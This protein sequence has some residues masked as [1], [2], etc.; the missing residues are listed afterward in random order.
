METVQLVDDRKTNGNPPAVYYR[1]R[2]DYRALIPLVRHGLNSNDPQVRAFLAQN[3]NVKMSVDAG[4]QMHASDIL[5]RHLAPANLK[6][7]VVVL[8]PDSGDLLA[9]VSYPWPEEDQFALFRKNADRTIAADWQDRALFGLYPPGSSFKLVT[10][11]AALR[12]NPNADREVFE[13]KALGDGRVG[14]YVGK[15]NRPIRDDIQDKIPHGRVDMT[16][17]IIVS[18]NAFFAQLGYAMGAAPLLETAQ[19]FHIS[20]SPGDSLARLRQRLPQAAYGQGEVVAT[21]FQMARVAATIADNGAMPQGRWVIDESNTRADEPVAVLDVQ[22]T[23]KIAS[24]MRQVV[25][26]PAGTGKVLRNAPIDIAGKTG[27]AQLDRGDAHAWFIGYAP[28]Q[29][30]KGK[31]IAFAVLVEHG[32]YGGKTAAPIAG[33]IVAA[34]QQAGLIAP[35]QDRQ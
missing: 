20:A 13:C 6:G 24:A 4:L 8:D 29:A 23:Q 5:R 2:Y 1:T 28:Y 35:A 22:D 34:A 15:S 16:K 7:A 14:N 33:E 10:A 18:C 9:S 12:Q 30:G 26:S 21:P 32:E 3:R 17:G 31:R 19:L 11:I 27:T 25:T